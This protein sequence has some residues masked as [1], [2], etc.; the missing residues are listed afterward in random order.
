MFGIK[1]F[2]IN[3]IRWRKKILWQDSEKLPEEYNTD[4]LYAAVDI[5]FEKKAKESDFTIE[6]Y[7][8]QPPEIVHASN[9]PAGRTWIDCWDGSGC[10]QSP[11]RKNFFSYDLQT[12]EFDQYDN[13]YWRF[14]GLPMMLLAFK[15][16]AEKEMLKNKDNRCV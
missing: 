13:G 14:W 10:L 16:F 5:S 4:K 11:D 9:L 15:E 2:L 1:K 7:L 8:N 6:D 12:G 3:H